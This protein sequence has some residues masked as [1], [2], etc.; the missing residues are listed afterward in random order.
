MIYNKIE[1]V[2]VITKQILNY[3]YTN[4]SLEV[5]SKVQN[6]HQKYKFTQK[7]S[8]KRNFQMPSLFFSSTTTEWN[9]QDCGIPKAVKDTSM[10]LSKIYQMKVSH[11]T[12][13]EANFGLRRA[14]MPSYL[15][16]LPLNAAFFSFRMQPE[17]VR[18]RVSLRERQKMCA[19][20]ANVRERDR[21]NKYV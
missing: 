5:K 7:L 10:L 21:V 6:V 19:K 20:E 8:T 2:L 15:R 17:C 18:E 9:A 3:Y 12:G 1:Q 11:K 14:L 13:S 4:F 16:M